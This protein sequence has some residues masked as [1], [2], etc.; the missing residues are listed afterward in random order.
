MTFELD[1]ITRKIDT[2][3][4]NMISSDKVLVVDA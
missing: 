2:L 3:I 4:N 1:S